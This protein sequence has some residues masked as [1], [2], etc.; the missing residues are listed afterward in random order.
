MYGGQGFDIQD[1]LLENSAKLIILPFKRWARFT[2]RKGQSTSHVAKARMHVERRI[3][4]IKDYWI[5][6][7]VLPW[8]F[9]DHISDMF[10]ICVALTALLPSVLSG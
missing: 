6:K 10:K 1:L 2:K 8:L 9:N 5:F 3:S 7:T 4:R